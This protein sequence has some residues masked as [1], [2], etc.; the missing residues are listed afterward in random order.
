MCKSVEVEIKEGQ[1]LSFADADDYVIDNK[2]GWLHLK[3]DGK[4][5]GSILLS[6]VCSVH[7]KKL[8]SEI[9]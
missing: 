5:R 8:G 2:E 6:R 4:I 1:I 7:I 3:I 9:K